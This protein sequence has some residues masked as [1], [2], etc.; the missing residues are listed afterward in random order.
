VVQYNTDRGLVTDQL[1]PFPLKLSRE[2]V[3]EEDAAVRVLREDDVS[4]RA[5]NPIGPADFSG[6]IQ[7][8]ALN[9]P[10]SWD[11]RYRALLEMHDTGEPEKRGALL[12]AQHGRGVYVY[13]GLAFFR[14]LPAGV[15]GALRLF[16]NLLSS[17]RQR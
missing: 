13:T 17:G 16:A 5:P 9:L 6:W 11:E 14:E 4:L 7:E 8:R 10:A 3:A 2:R 15:P 12:V 1:G